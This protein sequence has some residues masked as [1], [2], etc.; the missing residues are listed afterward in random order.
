[1]CLLIAPADGRVI[2]IQDV[3]HEP[4]YLHGPAKQVSIFLSPLNVHVNRIP[5]DGVIEFDQYVP[6]EYLV[7]WHEKASEK[8]ERSQ[9]GLVHPSGHRVLFKQI[10]GAIARRIVY[11][12]RV[13]DAV[14]AGAALRHRPLRLAHGHPRA[15][16]GRAAGGHWRHHGGRARRSW[17]ASPPAATAWPPAPRTTPP[18][19][20]PPSDGPDPAPPRPS[21][22]GPPPP[23][24]PPGGGAVVLHA[25]EPVLRLSGRGA[26]SRGAVR[27]RV[28]ARRARRRV[29][30]FRRHD[31][32]PDGLAVGLWRR[33][34]LARRRRLVRARAVVPRLRLRPLRG[35]PARHRRLLAARALR[36][37][38]PGP[39]QRPLRRREE[40]ELHRPPHPDAGGHGR[41]ARAQRRAPR[42]PVLQPGRPQPADSGRRRVGA[43]D[44][45]HDPVRFGPAPDGRPTSAPIRGGRFSTPSACSSWSCCKRKACSSRSR[46]TSARA[47]A[48]PCGALCA[49]C[50][51][52]RPPPPPSLR[53]PPPDRVHRTAPY[54]HHAPAFHPRPAGQGHP[55]R[56]RHARL[57]GGRERPH[58][59]GGRHAASTPRTPRG[60]RARP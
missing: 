1:M 23:P 5:A 29:R 18:Q 9:L 31:G 60:R 14:K 59:Q 53:A 15:A 39:L 41:G 36:G 34:R 55:P 57:S 11:H 2:L 44:G 17:A 16:V 52:A 19:P 54:P 33:T 12:A 37:R 47:W 50:A 20:S 40:D 10:A 48:S 22:D 32:A 21:R 27:E 46:P 30:P 25:H 49:S 43:A 13:G 6:G 42:L 56:P 8:N 51:P 24:H 28:L 45:V 38:A 58:G 3:A 26:D 4:L 35:G 7:A